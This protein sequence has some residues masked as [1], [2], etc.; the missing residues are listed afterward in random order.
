MRKAKS[1]YGCYAYSHCLNTC[2]LNYKTEIYEWVGGIRLIRP[3][4][5]C[6]KPKTTGEYIKRLSE[7][8][9]N[10]IIYEVE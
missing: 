3:V 2:L 9:K 1:C 10:N 6:R 8:V 4:K 5:C 7:V